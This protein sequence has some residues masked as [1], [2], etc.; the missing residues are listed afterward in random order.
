MSDIDLQQ[1]LQQQQLQ[2][3]SPIGRSVSPSRSLGLSFGMGMGAVLGGYT[4]ASSDI[5]PV[6]SAVGFSPKPRPSHA[7]YAPLRY[8]NPHLRG[9]VQAVLSSTYQAIP[10]YA[11]Y[12]I[13]LLYSYTYL[14]NY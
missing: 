11:S 5:S 7:G 6:P 13:Y 12:T 3:R 8:E 4:S 9:Q 10:Y 1:Q 14:C 2:Q